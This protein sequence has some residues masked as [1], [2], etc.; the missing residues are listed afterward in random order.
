MSNSESG[1]HI[2]Y[3]QYKGKYKGIWSW[4]LSTDHK[5]IGLL[6][7][8]SVVVFFFV[9]VILGLLM[10]IELIAPGETIMGPQVYNGI[11]TIHGV[12]MI[13]VIVI[14]ALPAIFGNFFLQ[15]CHDPLGVGVDANGQGAGL[16]G[17]R[18]DLGGG[19]PFLCHD[20]GSQYSPRRRDNKST[21]RFD[22]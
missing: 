17:F 16:R 3:L 6:Y 18:S 9:A 7:L 21:I 2:S 12:I 15:R 19:N 11:F 10:R 13:F 22:L 4:L 14:P 8:Y 1:I 20:L 5:R